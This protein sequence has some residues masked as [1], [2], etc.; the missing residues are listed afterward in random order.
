MT[1]TKKTTEQKKRQKTKGLQ[2]LT[3]FKIKSLL[4]PWSA[5][6]NAPSKQGPKKD[7]PPE[8]KAERHCD[9]GGLY[10]QITTEGTPSWLFRY[11]IHGKFR[12]MGLGALHLVGLADA[13]KAA[14]DCRVQLQKGIDPLEDKRQ[15]QLTKRIEDT[16]AITFKQCATNHHLA[17][18]DGW[19]N[20]KHAAQWTNTLTTYAYPV[21]GDL[22]VTAVDVAKIMEILE[23]IWM[24]KTETASRLRGRI[25]SIL[26]WATAKGYRTGDNPARLK[27]HLDHLLINRSVARKV[28]HHPALPYLEIGD[29]VDLLKTQ[30]GIA[31]FA[32]EFVI[33]TATRTSEVIN[34]TYSEIEFDSKTWTIPGQRMK[35]GC[36][37]R[38][39]LSDRAIEILR[40]MEAHKQHEYVFPGRIFKKPLSNM[41]LLQLLRRMERGDLTVHGFRAT[42]RTWAGECTHYPRETLEAALAHT[43]KDKTEAAYARGTLFEK[44]RLLM[45]DWAAYCAKPLPPPSN[46]S[47][48]G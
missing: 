8:R 13:R 39:P 29:F 32:L 38:V 19:K 15:K 4:E 36:E 17:K 5:I 44:R 1:D 46:S 45:S 10:L 31:P 11:Q 18:K 30:E 41:A 25:E 20:A 48:S 7:G 23:P 12:A 37:H 3:Q 40:H 35:S 26:D 47:T 34:M 33:L 22:P 21:I 14:H 6:K 27:G 2:N 24:T 9:G 43:L 16:E 42:F 28:E